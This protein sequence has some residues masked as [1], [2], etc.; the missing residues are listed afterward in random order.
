MYLYTHSFLNLLLYKSGLFMEIT[1]LYNYG[2]ISWSIKLST[3]FLIGTM[4]L[5]TK[6]LLTIQLL[7]LKHS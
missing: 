7:S 3:I 5:C 1:L 2:I 6:F 4:Y